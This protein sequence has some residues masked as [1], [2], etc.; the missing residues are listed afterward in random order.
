MSTAEPGR[1]RPYDKDL[2]WR[3]IYQPIGMTLTYIRI[4]SNLNVSIATCQRIYTKFV[5]IGTIDPIKLAERRDVR[6]LDEH[7]ELHVIGRVHLSRIAVR[8]MR[9][10]T[11]CA[12]FSGARAMWL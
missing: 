12:R 6:R 10:I 1:R 9:I 5:Q 11:I 7:Q 8:I 4:A 3:I 2:R